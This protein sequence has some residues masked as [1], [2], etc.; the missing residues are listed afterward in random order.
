MTLLEDVKSILTK[1]SSLTIIFV[2]ALY[3]LVLQYFFTYKIVDV[4]NNIDGSW[5]YTLSYL[6]HTGQT[7]GVNVFFNYGP[8]FERV[9]TYVTA[10]DTLR[11]FLVTNL[12]FLLLFILNIFG[13]Y[14]FIKLYAKRIGIYWI[15][16][17]TVFLALSAIQIESIFYFTLIFGVLAIRKELRLDYRLLMLI[18]L[19]LFSLY[20][21]SFT[22]AFLLSSPLIF[23]Y[24]S[25]GK[26]IVMD[27]VGS[28]FV[29]FIIYCTVTEHLSLGFFK[30][31]YYGLINSIFYNEFMSLTFHENKKMTLVYLLVMI[32]AFFIFMVYAVKLILRKK[33]KAKFDYLVFAALILLAS[34]LSY[35][36]SVVRSDNG[37]M[38][39]FP[40]T[41]FLLSTTTAA[42]V[43]N[44][45]NIKLKPIILRL[46]LS[47][48]F[49]LSL[50][51][52][53]IINVHYSGVGLREFGGG[54]FRGLANSLEDNRLNYSSFISNRN[55][56]ARD[57][58]KRKV[59]VESINKQ[60]A[61]LSGPKN[62]IVFGNTTLLST[63]LYKGYNVQQA[64]FLQNYAAHPP[65]LFDRIYLDNVYKN[66]NDLI[67]VEETEGSVNE[68]MVS[69]E[70]NNYFQYLI[71]NY[72][73]IAR[74]DARR[75]YVLED[76]SR[77]LQ[78]CIPIRSFTS[79]ENALTPLP[80]L[81]TSPNNYVQ[82]VVHIDSTSKDKLASILVK[83][84]VYMMNI[85]SPDGMMQWRVTKTTLAHGVAISPLYLNFHDAINH[86]GFDLKAIEISGGISQNQPY[87]A[88]L[89]MCSF[90]NSV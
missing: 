40:S 1:R 59:E 79:N 6:R 87:S 65:Q 16:L 28:L 85:Y 33:I 51:S 20:K 22:L 62:I 89:N 74:N 24:T 5:Q 32:I 49:L 68:R 44:I 39:T 69:Y 83:T 60:L 13:L 55:Q 81:Q 30:Y 41:I 58:S 23:L 76:V 86:I 25:R 75:Q 38:L 12:F 46:G 90:H 36:E 77:N 48:L 84:P 66:P 9:G 10:A 21:F 61:A 3:G 2:L 29:L 26:R 56:T 88:Q 17:A 14:R 37:H 73:V 80:Q 52:Y 15:G 54:E 64:P 7:L 47:T 78:S 82:M 70:L 8:L 45:I 18:G 53:L 50:I 57:I 63:L 19:E 27:W 72:K 4:H 11:D 67:F 43:L 35:K 34:Y 71:H 31:L 42:I